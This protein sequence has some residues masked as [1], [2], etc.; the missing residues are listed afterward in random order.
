MGDVGSRD[1]SSPQEAANVA[2]MTIN[3]PCTSIR[4]C[5]GPDNHPFHVAGCN[6]PFLPGFVPKIQRQYDGNDKERVI[7]TQASDTVPYA[8]RSLADETSYS[9]NLHRAQNIARSS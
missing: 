1:P 5:G 3:T 7:E 4:Q 6:R 9:M 2:A 8:E